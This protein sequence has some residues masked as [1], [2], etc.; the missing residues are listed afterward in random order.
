MRT[1]LG[2]SV[3]LLGAIMYCVTL[4]GGYFPALLLGGYVLLIE[5][6]QWLRV[7]VVKSLVLLTSITFLSDLIQLIPEILSWIN[8]LVS[9]FDGSFKYDTISSVI[10]LV[11]DALSII[12]TSLFLM[13]GATALNQT[14]VS[15]PVVDRLLKKYY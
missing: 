2:I 15:I 12:K 9:K 4:F 13:L 8:T 6:N 3:G 11:L 10:K 14:T 1:K 5:E 7:A